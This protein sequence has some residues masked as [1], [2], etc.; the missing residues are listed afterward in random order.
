MRD[1][2]L[3]SPSISS[4]NFGEP[5]RAMQLHLRVSSPAEPGEGT[6]MFM[7][8]GPCQ[9]MGHTACMLWMLQGMRYHHL[10]LMSLKDTGGKGWQK[11]LIPKYWGRSSVPR[12]VTDTSDY[13]WAVKQK[14]FWLCGRG[15]WG[16]AARAFSIIAAGRKNWRGQAVPLLQPSV[17]SAV[18][19]LHQPGL[20]E[21]LCPSALTP[22]HCWGRAAHRYGPGPKK[23]RSILLL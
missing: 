17:H 13:R 22:K 19:Q 20:E 6:F 3:L 7:A 2:L 4:K 14:G 18:A 9:C 5:H 16:T 21:P 10:H 15:I 11:A 12:L 8:V 23:A 1:F